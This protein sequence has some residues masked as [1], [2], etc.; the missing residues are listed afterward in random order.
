MIFLLL[1]SFLIPISTGLSLVNLLLVRYTEIKIPFLLKISL[2]VGLG[3]GFSSCLSFLWLLLFGTFNRGFVVADLI[4]CLGT[5]S[6]YAIQRRIYPQPTTPL[7][8]SSSSVKVHWLIKLCFYVLLGYALLTFI[9][10]FLISPHGF[11]DAWAI[12]NTR[13][14]FLFRGFEY[15]KDAFSPLIVVSDYPLLVPLTVARSWYYI[16]QETQL[17]PGLIALLFTF[18]TVGLMVSA[19]STFRTKT[20]GYLAGMILMGTPFLIFHGVS[21]YADVPLGFFYFSVIILF[22]LHDQTSN[23]GYGLLFLAGLMAGFSGW[24]KNE[25][26]LFTLS[27]PLARLA[28]PGQTL[29]AYSMTMLFF[30]IGLSPVLLIIL[31]LKTQLAPLNY[32]FSQDTQGLLPKVMDLSRYF[33]ILKAFGI[34]FINFGL[35]PKL[36]LIPLL[37]LYACLLG[38]SI[39]KNWGIIR[40]P[41]IL[42][43][44]VSAGYFMVFL[45]TTFELTFQLRTTLGRLFLHLWPS[46]LFIYFIIVN[47]PTNLEKTQ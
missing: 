4:I 20:Q 27:I 41:L 28:V 39:R 33:Q 34:N 43:G 23:P 14:R 35:F 13:A 6:L 3:L 30:I 36:S 17:V 15:W 16:K 18:S 42:L 29:K 19:Q 9:L 47:T 5:I 1:F 37:G 26:L 7:L 40:A 38:F 8:G 45:C 44:L 46:A 12:W 22:Y 2:S 11:W 31:I 10:L 21:Q 32:L 25:G 24:T